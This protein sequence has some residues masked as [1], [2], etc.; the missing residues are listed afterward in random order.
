MT[1]E[2]LSD[3]QLA[4][5]DVLWREGEAT[6][7]RVREALATER[8]LAPTTVATILTRLEKRGVVER[9]PES[10]PFAYRA[11]VTRLEVRRSTITRILDRLFQGD[12]AS[13]VSHLVREGEM[14]P[15]DLVA[16][17]KRLETTR[18]GDD[19]S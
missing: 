16:L 9:R 14:D 3:L 15:R 2:R 1:S 10:R 17:K 18:E 7:A 6:V 12:P 11:A 19:E 8:D 13:L 4:V 5:L